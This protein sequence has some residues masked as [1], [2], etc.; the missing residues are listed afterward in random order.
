[1]G[2]G[3]VFFLKNEILKFIL[4]LHNMRNLGVLFSVGNDRPITGEN[5]ITQNYG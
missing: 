1:M 5:I 3:K 4:K 2:Y